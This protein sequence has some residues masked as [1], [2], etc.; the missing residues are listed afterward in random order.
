[1]SSEALDDFHPF[2]VEEVEYRTQFT[3]KFAKRKPYTPPKPKEITAFIPGTII[4]V[5]VKDNQ[6]VNKGDD[7]IVLQA[8]KMN[9]HLTAPK[10]G[11]IKKVYVKQGDRV[12]KNQILLEFK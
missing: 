7:L 6:K 4:K 2:F 10:K 8:M 3:K 5:F 1:M 9:N 11:M 12:P